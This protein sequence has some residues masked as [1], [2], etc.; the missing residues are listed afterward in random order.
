MHLT[1]TVHALSTNTTRRLHAFYARVGAAIPLTGTVGRESC[2]QM[3]LVQR[4]NTIGKK[5]ILDEFPEV[6]QG[7]GCLPGKY[8][9]SINPSVPPIIHPPRRVPH[10]KW[11]LLKK[12]LDHM[13]NVGIIE[14]VPL[15]EPAVWVSSLVCVDKPDGSIRVCLDPRDLNRAIKREHYPLPLV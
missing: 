7:L 1:C 13:E 6:F 5:S 14:K 11:D 4:I 8:H 12:E 15:N 2:E 10:S 3:G 9:I